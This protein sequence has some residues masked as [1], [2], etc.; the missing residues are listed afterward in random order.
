MLDKIREKVSK[1]KGSTKF[2]VR[3]IYPILLFLIMHFL[4]VYGMN[5]KSSTVQLIFILLWA[6]LEWTIFLKKK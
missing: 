1:L 3:L 4:F 2:L 6:F 5:A